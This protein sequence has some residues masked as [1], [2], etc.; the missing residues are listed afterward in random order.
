FFILKL[1]RQSGLLYFHSLQNVLPVLPFLPF[2]GKNQRVVLDAH[3]LVAE[4]QR[5]AGT[6]WKSRLYE[7]SERR[8]FKKAHVVVTVTDAMERYFRHKLPSARVHYI[9]WTN[10]PA[11]LK[12]IDYQ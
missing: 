3:G 1:F 4:E 10:L 12:G 5:M 9:S 8:I 11:H 6:R 7:L 2:T